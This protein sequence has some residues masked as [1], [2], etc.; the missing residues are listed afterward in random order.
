M[1]F[2]AAAAAA[3][4]SI[5]GTGV[6]SAV[7][8]QQA[9]ENRSWM[10][11]MS[12]TAHQREVKDLLA[13]GLN[14]ILSAGG[15]GASTPGGVMPQIGDFGQAASRGVTSAIAV[16]RDKMERDQIQANVRKTDQDRA[17]SGE[18]AKA[19]AA[20]A[21]AANAQA[22]ATRT[23]ERIAR[24]GLQRQR[25]IEAWYKTPHGQM[26]L[27]AELAGK[28][29]S[30]LITGVGGALFG[31]ALGR[32]GRGGRGR[33]GPGR[34][35]P[36]RRGPAERQMGPYRPLKFKVTGGKSGKHSVKANRKGR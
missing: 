17:T 9:R 35:A 2:W 34:G 33:G 7:G 36:G 18:A 31:R 1:V 19:H 15:G 28:A 11:R 3:A 29:L 26:A 5:I 12:N 20:S 21:G 16:R 23:N 6:S 13:A 10:E 32:G 30:P 22:R 25:L 4:G 24:T 8:I 14:P 27:K